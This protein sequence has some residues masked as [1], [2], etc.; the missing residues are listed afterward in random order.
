[1]EEEQRSESSGILK[2]FRGRFAMARQKVIE[3]R[4]GFRYGGQSDPDL[5][6]RSL[7]RALPKI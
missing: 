7:K 2:K 5:N 4:F 1:V 3:S 6:E